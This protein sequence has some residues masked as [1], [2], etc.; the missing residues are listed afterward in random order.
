MPAIR[1]SL[2]QFNASIPVISMTSMT[3]ALEVGT[4]P[5]RALTT[6]LTLF[7][8]GSLLVAAIGLYGVIAFNMRK[9]TRDFGVR[10][11]LGASSQQILRSVLREG[12]LL[13]AAGVAAGS[14]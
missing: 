9:R 8:I 12:L 1:T 6:L 2:R 13:T 14:R 11:A 10:L 3:A 4:S 5:V 7:A